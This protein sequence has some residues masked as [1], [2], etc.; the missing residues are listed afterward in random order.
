M[1]A[2]IL[3]SL[4]LAAPNQ[5]GPLP[6]SEPAGA[7]Y[8]ITLA[9]DSAP[10]FTDVESYLRSVTSQY[11]TPQEKAIGVWRWSQRLRKQTSYPTEGGHAV[12]DPIFF[13]TSYGYTMCGLISGIDNGLWLNLGWKAHYVQLGDHTVCECS[14]DGGKTWH[15]FDNSMSFYCFNDKGEVASTREIEKDPTCY[16]QR[17]APEC[18]TNPVKG[19]GDHQGWRAASDRPVEYQRTLANGFDSFQPP[20]DV[21]EDHLAIRWGRRTVLNLRPGDTYTR[22]FSSLDGTKSDPRYYRPLRGKD[23]QSG[24][25]TRNIRANGVWIYAPDLK[26]PATRSRIYADSG[27]AWGPAGPTGPG[28]VIFKV[29]AANII[30]SAKITLQGS[31]TSVSLSRDSG[32]HWTPVR[33]ESGEIAL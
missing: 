2:L 7:D 18:G 14:W 26:S 6:A 10:D 11:S 17:F 33:E 13:F 12:N 16:L 1:R 19:P 3:S 9:T 24:N 32:N 4:L 30:T 29:S 20:N 5:A 21:I 23:V 31:G 15:M 28:W 22:Y 8:N 27:L 25:P